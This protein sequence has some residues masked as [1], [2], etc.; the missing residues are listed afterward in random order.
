MLSKQQ[1]EYLDAM[2]INVW[3]L[4]E[5]P[6]VDAV[7]EIAAQTPV[8]TTAETTADPIPEPVT[9]TQP[10]TPGLKLGPGRGG[11][12]L[13]CEEDSD[14]ASRLANDISRALGSVPV[15]SWPDYD[16]SATR[17]DVAV[18]DNLFTTVAIFGE[19]LARRFF[20]N[21]TPASVEAANLVHLPAMQEIAARAEA[22]RALWAALCRA[23]M[24][25][26][27]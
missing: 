2:G 8:Q 17:L 26:R 4:R 21:E 13:V 11:I 15:W 24:V 10:E 3:S 22:R 23:G 1:R 5:P 18:Q 9:D 7:A 25:S 6:V 20:T 12:L 14:S 16:A 19:D 27:V